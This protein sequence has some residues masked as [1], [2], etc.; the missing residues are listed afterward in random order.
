MVPQVQRR[1]ATYVFGEASKQFALGNHDA[2]YDMLHQTLRLN[3]RHAPALALL[4]QYENYL[5]N[6]D[7]AD[8]LLALALEIDPHNIDYLEMNAALSER[9]GD[10]E[11]VIDAFERLADAKPR[12]TR[13]MS[14]LAQLYIKADMPDSAVSVL[15]RL[16]SIQGVTEQVSN[17]KHRLLLDMGDTVAAM[18]QLHALVQEYPNDPNYA[19]LL[20]NAYARVLNMTDTAQAVYDRVALV[21]PNNPRLQ[22]ARL[23]LYQ[24]TDSVR[25]QAYYDSLLYC[26]G[27]DADLRKSLMLRFIGIHQYDSLS[28]QQTYDMF[29]RVLALPQDDSRLLSTY[30]AYLLAVKAGDDTLSTVL[31][32]IIDVEP[33]NRPAL[34]QLLQ[35]YARQNDS[36]QV[37]RVCDQ[38]ITY[39]PHEAVFYYYSALGYYSQGDTLTALER[40]T[41]GCEHINEQTT[42]SQ[43]AEMYVMQGDILHALSRNAEAYAAYDSCLVYEP[44]NIQCL[45]NYAYFLSLDGIDL[46]RAEEMS[47]RTVR[48]QPDSRTYL[49]TYAWILYL[50]Q[51]YDE[52]ANY[53]DRVMDGI[54]VNA[55]EEP[56]EVSAD[57][58]EHAGDIY[59]ANGDSSRAVI[60]WKA[61]LRFGCKSK[62]LRQK[63]RNK[64]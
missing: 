56:D 47:Y 45:N 64:E 18:N 17:T 2:A 46:A 34:L 26:Q 61:A 59:A 3:P 48:A 20:G 19:V 35:I 6:S 62:T 21:D 55:D 36:R 31:N 15:S 52:A 49:D 29:D 11:Y 57:V 58:F 54:D 42:G 53:M 32:R 41:V 4:A 43:A 9:N 50:Q 13:V 16:E 60:Y 39:Y 37:A 22:L 14:Q 40:V 10:I 7:K 27:T 30:V 5:R 25:Y 51:R 8:S 63:I 24:L 1:T 44:D 23:N 33:N 12:N 38:A 28:Q